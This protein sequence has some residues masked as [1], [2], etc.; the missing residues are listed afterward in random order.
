MV[1]SDKFYDS[2]AKDYS[3]VSQERQA[4]LESIDKN[5]TSILEHKKPSALLDIGSGNGE[6]IYKL[7][8]NRDVDVWVLENSSVMAEFLTKYFRTSRILRS[9]VYEIAELSKKFDTVTAL[10]NVFG[11]IHDIEQV[12][13][14]IKEKLT[15]DGIFIFD[16]NNPYNIA[17]YGIISVVRNW[18]ILGLRKK[19]LA[20]NLVRGVINTEVYFRS[21]NNY[22][23][24]LERAGFTKVSVS[25]VNYSSGKKTNLFGGQYYFECT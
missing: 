14:Q 6:R 10:W 13:I 3:A 11:H 21:L 22:R 25:F 19:S 8:C 15:N 1:S 24:M 23:I 5:L 12:L 4:Y 9:D 7:T 18:L 20:F 16:V 2:I 17:E